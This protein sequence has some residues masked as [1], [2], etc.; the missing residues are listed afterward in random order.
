MVIAVI[1]T[2]VKDDE[3]EEEKGSYK[4]TKRILEGTTQ[5][6]RAK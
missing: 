3:R 1:R 6:R 2:R 5:I 4:R